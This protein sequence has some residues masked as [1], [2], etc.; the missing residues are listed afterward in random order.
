M[1]CDGSSEGEIFDIEIMVEPL[2]SVSKERGFELQI[3]KDTLNQ[4]LLV[5]MSQLRNVIYSFQ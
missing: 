1:S 4:D 3:T 5:K 2:L